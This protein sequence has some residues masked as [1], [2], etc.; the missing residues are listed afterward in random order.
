MNT[1][2]ELRAANGSV[3]M[4]LAAEGGAAWSVTLHTD[5]KDIS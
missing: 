5:T 2:T 4:I 3:I 1:N